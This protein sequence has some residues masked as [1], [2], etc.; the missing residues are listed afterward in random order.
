MS[1]CLTGR[2]CFK[3]TKHGTQWYLVLK[4]SKND[5]QR[6]SD[7]KLS[8]IYFLGV[9]IYVY[10][11]INNCLLL[12]YP[13]AIVSYGMK[14]YKLSIHC[15]TLCCT[16]VEKLHRTLYLVFV[17]IS[18]EITCSSLK[19]IAEGSKYHIYSNLVFCLM[20]QLSEITTS[21]PLLSSVNTCMCICW[22]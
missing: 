21:F 6:L 15:A 4:Q 5:G 13:F 11:Y 3:L 22:G 1:V 19:T 12:F 18:C 8:Q 10:M 7:I 2:L 17:L 16:R 14:D 20:R 9:H